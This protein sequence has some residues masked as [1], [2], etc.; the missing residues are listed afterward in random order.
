V[1]SKNK[2]RERLGTATETEMI[3][4]LLKV[5]KVCKHSTC[6][7]I[8]AYLIFITIILSLT[9]PNKSKIFHNSISKEQNE[10]TDFSIKSNLKLEELPVKKEQQ[11]VILLDQKH[12]GSN[13]LRFAFKK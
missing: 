9:F 1:I 6:L 2:Q 3:V 13:I 11:T 7:S 12:D 4:K 5:F 10:A 8:L